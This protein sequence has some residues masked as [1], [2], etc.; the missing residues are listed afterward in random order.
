MRFHTPFF[1]CSPVFCLWK[2]QKKRKK[3]NQSLNRIEWCISTPDFTCYLLKFSSPTI[4]RSSPMWTFSSNKLLY[5]QSMSLH[6]TKYFAISPLKPNLRGSVWIL[7]IYLQL[8]FHSSP[9]W[10]KPGLTIVS[11][12]KAYLMDR[13]EWGL[14]SLSF[15]IHICAG[16]I[17]SNNSLAASKSLQETVISYSIR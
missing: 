8:W 14:R 3:T 9:E 7:M 12:S 13:W 1:C 17:L 16:C 4:L 5:P 2:C 6:Y 10:T 15:D 11:Q